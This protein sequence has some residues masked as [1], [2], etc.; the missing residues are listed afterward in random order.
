MHKRRSIDLIELKQYVTIVWMMQI[1][2]TE[3]LDG[4]IKLLNL[5]DIIESGIPRD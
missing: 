5:T 1:Q 4:Q 2:I 3:S